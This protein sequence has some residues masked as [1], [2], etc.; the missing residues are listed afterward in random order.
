MQLLKTETNIL[1]RAYTII[2]VVISI[3][4]LA[5]MLLSLYGGFSAG[6]A[7]VKLS[8]ENLRATQLMVQKMET[9]RLLKWSQISNTS[10]APTTFTDYYDPTGTNNGTAGVL[11]RGF[12]NFSNCAGLFTDYGSN[13]ASVTVSVYWTNYP[14]KPSTYVI[15]R[16]R[17]MQTF[18]ARFGM[19]NYIYQ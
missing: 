2:E 12:C 19:Q 10:L 6:F 11:Y 8:R 5:I 15:V 4:I 3:V 9:V 13:L 14:M 7:V 18:V 16:H 17:Q 1:P